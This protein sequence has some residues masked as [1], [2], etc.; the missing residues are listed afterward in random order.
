M[1]VWLVLHDLRIYPKSLKQMELNKFRPNIVGDVRKQ[2]LTPSK[3]SWKIKSGSCLW[4]S[5][6]F[7]PRVVLVLPLTKQAIQ[8]FFQYFELFYYLS[9]FFLLTQKENNNLNQFT[10][11]MINICQTRVG[12]ECGFWFLS[13]VSHKNK[14]IKSNNWVNKRKPILPDNW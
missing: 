8:L 9:W 11:T 2:A 5:I 12:T 1:V 3:T 7:T 10:G 14:I 6:I 13:L 4:T